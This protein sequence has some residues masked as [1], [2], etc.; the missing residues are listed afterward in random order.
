M[1]GLF[2]HRRRDVS[3]AMLCMFA[4]LIAGCSAVDQPQPNQPAAQTETAQC[5][6]PGH[7]CQTF[8]GP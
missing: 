8:F 3:A 7:F 5:R 1:L 4:S 2:I 6:V